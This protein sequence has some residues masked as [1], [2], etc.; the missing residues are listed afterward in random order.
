MNKKH[1]LLLIAAA[2]T[3]LLPYVCAC[4]YIVPLADD[5]CNAWE[6]LR[7]ADLLA[8][9]QHLYLKMNG[10]FASHFFLLLVPM[11]LVYYRLAAFV[12]MI[13][14]IAVYYWAASRLISSRLSAL[15]TALVLELFF[16]FQLPDLSE[17]A[18]WYSG[19]MIYQLSALVF[20]S[21]ILLVHSVVKN[22]SS[23][24]TLRFVKA[25]I[26]AALAFIT[27]GFNEPIAVISFLYFLSL[28]ALAIFQKKPWNLLGLY[29]LV[30]TA[31]MLVLVYSPGSAIRASH[32]HI[33]RSVIKVLAMTHLQIIRFA[34]DWV[35]NLPFVL[36]ALIVLV[37]ADR[38]RTGILKSIKLW[39]LIAAIYLVFLSCILLPYWF[40]GMLGQ[41]RTVDLAY[42]LIIPLAILSL[43]KISQSKFYF[44]LLS[45]LSGQRMITAFIA[46]AIFFMAVTKNG[47]KISYDLVSGTLPQYAAEQQGRAQLLS[48]HLHEDSYK[49]PPVEHKPL[50]ITLYDESR[51]DMQWVQKCQCIYQ[52]RADSLT[53][54]R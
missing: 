27:A 21:T 37:R 3:A 39:W 32:Y 43:I 25:L 15:L 50:S 19:Y 52:Q 24:S 26:A 28:T 53:S 30:S 41:Q 12:V 18:Y 1:I 7:Y 44:T 31:G 38:V 29:W 33:D 35:S 11:D 23:N 13:A 47:Y 54:L 16:L 34:A 17:G 48:V 9:V 42:Y 14:S 4:L 2:I 8:G 6:A 10:R 45:F 22:T 46:A 49:L 20:I 5:Y 36:L 40:T 51:P